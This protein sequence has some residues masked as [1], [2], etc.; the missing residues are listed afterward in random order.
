[1]NLRI[2]T[3]IAMVILFIFSISAFSQDIIRAINQGD[4]EQVKTL[5]EKNPELLNIKDNNGSTLLHHAVNKGHKE[6]VELL[7]AKRADINAKNG[8]GYTPLD[9][10][11]DGGNS[12]I[13]EL[14]KSK[15][16]QITPVS[17]AKVYPLSKTVSRIVFP[18]HMR[19][20]IAASIGPDGIL[21]IDT[22]FSKRCVDKLK[23]KLQELGDG[24][25]KYIIN[26]HHH[27][28]HIA[29]NSIAGDNT[30]IIGY[31]DLE[32][33]LS[34]GIISKAKEPLK[35]KTG[36]TFEN[37]YT[38]QFNGEEI[39]IIP[40]PGIHSETDL[41]IYFP[42]SKIADMGDLLLSQSFPAVGKN[43]IAYLAFLETAL[44]IFPEDTKFISGHGKDSTYEDVKNY[45]KMLLTTIEI[46]KKEMVK[47]KSFQDMQKEKVLNDY[48]SW[49][50]FLT[51]LNTDYWINAVYACYKD[52]K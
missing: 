6:I 44:D 18:F 1:M 51:F 16:A 52:K 28:D 42:D 10:I 38:M 5:L 9:W 14:L 26:T 34:E 45:Q 32:Q 39:K 13:V 46:I 27:G 2:I 25:I 50:T 19:T 36:K 21:L 12:E 8:M 40:N 33:L 23:A 29:G 22:G 17:D 49:G 41:I 37:Y 35:G 20:N 31:S 11:I 43:V 7:I 15:G 4:L 48:E 47:G 3:F 24:D 30:K